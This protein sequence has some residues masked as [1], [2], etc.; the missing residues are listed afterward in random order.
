MEKKK[1]SSANPWDFPPEAD[2]AAGLKMCLA[3]IGTC[4]GPTFP[5]V[6]SKAAF[7]SSTDPSDRGRKHSLLCDFSETLCYWWVSLNVNSS[8]MNFHPT[9]TGGLQS[10]WPTEPNN[11]IK[12]QNGPKFKPHETTDF[13]HFKSTFKNIYCNVYVY[14]YILCIYTI[15]IY[16]YRYKHMYVINLKIYTWILS[17]Y[18][19]SIY[20]KSI[21]IL[22]LFKY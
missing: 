7:S 11:W 14:I 9:K 5:A 17:M 12:A 18:A 22:N 20:N 15:Y 8:I 13:D 4:E 1:S 6:W 10:E 2:T 16:I 3:M 21:N 19:L